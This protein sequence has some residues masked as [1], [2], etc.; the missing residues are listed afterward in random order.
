MAPCIPVLWRVLAVATLVAAQAPATPGIRAAI[1]QGAIDKI[2]ALVLAAVVPALD[3]VSVPFFYID[4]DTISMNMYAVVRPNGEL[5]IPLSIVGK[6][7]VFVLP[8]A[9]QTLSSRALHSAA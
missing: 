3:N 6:K 1:S 2:K 4:Q 9:G 5:H 7:H 8:L